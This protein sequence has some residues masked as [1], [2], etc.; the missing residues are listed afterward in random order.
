MLSIKGIIS[1]FSTYNT[2]QRE[3]SY[4]EVRVIESPKDGHCM[5]TSFRN[6]L[7]HSKCPDTPS[8]QDVLVKLRQEIM[9][10]LDFYS[11]F[12][13]LEE[14][15]FMS[16]LERFIE[17]RSYGSPTADI[18]LVALANA[19]EATISILEETESGYALK[20]P[21]KNHIY[22]HRINSS[23]YEILILRERDHYDAII[24]TSKLWLFSSMDVFVCF[25]SFLIQ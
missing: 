15:D 12:L 3:C 19:F 8:H 1:Y 5:I 23:Q 2:F 4:E 25:S 9:N 18:V 11:D 24:G 13:A 20:T 22:P 17:E 16:E 6:S 14:N 10:H 21:T 7:Q